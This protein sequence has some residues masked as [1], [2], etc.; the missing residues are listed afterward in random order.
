MSSP[1]NIYIHYEKSARCEAL[2]KHIEKYNPSSTIIFIRNPTELLNMDHNIQTGDILFILNENAILTYGEYYRAIIE[3]NEGYC[4]YPTRDH[5]ILETSKSA[6]RDMLSFK[7]LVKYNIDY[8]ILN[9]DSPIP[10]D[11]GP[12]YVIKA[13]GIT[14]GKGVFVGGE[15]FSTHEEALHIIK[16]LF[17]NH[18]KIVIEER[19]IGEEFSVI[20]FCWQGQFRHFP[21][22]KDFKRRNNGN[23]GH[24]TSGMGTITFPGG[25]MPF[26]SQIEYE[27]CCVLNELVAIGMAGGFTG[28][29]YGSFMKTDQDIKLIDYNVRP[30]D[31]EAVNMFAMLESSLINYIINPTTAPFH[32]NT[33]EYTYFRYIVPHHYPDSKS[34]TDESM[35]NSNLIIIPAGIPDD[36]WYP[37]NVDIIFQKEGERIYKMSNSRAGGIYTHHTDYELAI[38][39]NDRYI[40]GIAGHFHYRTDIGK[41]FPDG[42]G[43]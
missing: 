9:R 20:T 14:G 16:N 6:M 42:M 30:G 19:L 37:A 18:D 35:I 25:L 27:K 38:A 15:H 28:F 8:H 24:N 33:Q 1:V 23:T 36:V 34:E 29:L 10:Q 17:Q 26:I 5:A 22:I 11:I 40:A 31:S 32:I 41:W 43:D 21:C 39:D 13:D 12:N 3:S 2:I 7:G 4:I